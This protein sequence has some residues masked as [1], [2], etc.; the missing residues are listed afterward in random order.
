M[1]LYS[2]QAS[3]L[4]TVYLAG[5]KN[6]DFVRFEVFMVVT[7]KNAVFWNVVPCRY[8]VK[9]STWRC[10]PEDGILQV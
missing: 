10:I 5:G 2:K 7:M 9:I 3:H 8:F 1:R 4:E 6:Y